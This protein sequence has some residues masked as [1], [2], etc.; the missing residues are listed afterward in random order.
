MDKSKIR[1]FAIIAHIDHGKSTL[2]D[3]ILE[4]T[5]TVAKRDLEE[6][7]LDT[8]DLERERGIT[9]KLNAVQIKYKDYIFHLIDTPGH[10]DFTYEVSRSLAATE[11]ALLIV[12][13]TQGIEAQT[14][15]NVYLAIENNLT[16]IPIINKIDLP[17]ADIERTKEEIERVIGLDCSNAVAIS[18][19]T[20]LNIEQVLEAIEKYI[21]APIEADDNKPLQALIFDSY[22][23]EYRG[24]VMLV[25]IVQGQLKKNDKIQFMSNGK[26]NQVSELGVKSPWEVKKDV[27]RAGELGWVAAT[28]RDA[29][30]VSVG[31]TITLAEMPAEKPLPGYKKK[32]PVVFTGFYPIDTRDYMELKE[33]LEKISLSDSSISWEQETSKALGFGFRVGFLGML[34]M[35]ILQERLNREYA[36][37]VIATSP[38]VEY[39]VYK[40]DGTLEMISNPSLL[41]DKTYIDRIEEPYIFATIIVPDNFIGNVMDLCQNKRGVYKDMESLD[42]NRS[43]ITYEMPLAEIV[44]DFFDRLKSSTKGYASFEYDL[45]GYKETDL[46]KVDVLL[47]GDKIDAF[48]II[49]HRDNAYPR[50]RELCQKLKEAIPRQNFEVPV[51]AAIG[52]K[53]IARETIKAYRKDVTAKLYGGDVTRRQKLLKKQKEGKKRMKMLGSVEVPQEAFLKILKTNIEN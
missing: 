3:R 8:M 9:I 26:L 20:G 24:V 53:I 17:S 5:Q 41:P 4:L 34:H 23:D 25:R 31:D 27:L 47:N 35:E 28:I 43:K 30:E 38:S 36:I 15:A 21:P 46:V 33:S 29:R 7:I 45:F 40:T 16:I 37:S 39:K 2:A 19:K 18:A 44:V 11:G 6:Q 10:V 14:L 32:Q 42:G 51:Q 49:T 48:T 22:F 1:N 12:D 13:A 52:G 50:A